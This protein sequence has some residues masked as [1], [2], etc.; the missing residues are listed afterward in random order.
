M[1][2]NELASDIAKQAGALLLDVRR[3]SGLEGKALGK[4]GDARAN[5]LILDRLHAA[6]PEDGIL[7]EESTDDPL[8]LEKRRCWIVDPLDG[9]R[10]YSEGRSDWAVHVGLSIDGNPAGGAIALPAQDRIL[11]CQEPPPLPGEA[12]P[13]RILVSRTRAPAMA[14]KIAEALGGTTIPMGSAG[15]KVAAVMLGDGD[16]YLHA[17]GQYE[18]DNCAPVA[19]AMA[20]GLHCSRIDGAALRY[21]QRDVGVPDL[22][23]CHEERASLLLELI[24]RAEN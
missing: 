12:A 8:R 3:T 13:P 15:A 21:N 24:A 23:V 6:R 11:S 5:R 16:A 7:S 17:G 22:L 4:A 18:W 2:D 14:A 10:E 9:T 1:T 20:A 19:V